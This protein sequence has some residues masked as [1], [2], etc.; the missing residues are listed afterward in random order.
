MWCC[1]MAECTKRISTAKKSLIVYHKNTHF[2]KYACTEC[3]EVFPQKSR[4]EVHVRTTHSGEKPYQC[5]HCERAFPQMSNLNDHVKKTHMNAVANAVTSVTPYSE[6][7]QV[8]SKILR[9]KNPT[10]KYTQ[11]VCEI[12]KLW[13]LGNKCHASTI[14]GEYPGSE[15]TGIPISHSSNLSPDHYGMNICV[16]MNVL[17]SGNM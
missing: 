11:L 1:G 16:E 6:F 17:A 9:G 14:P 12:G 5:K 15:F 4:L 10:M 2:P 8:Q 13:R 7:Y 3:S